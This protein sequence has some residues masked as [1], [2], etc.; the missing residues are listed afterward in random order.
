MDKC[1][2]CGAALESQVQWLDGPSILYHCGTQMS[3]N[4]TY[5]EKPCLERQLTILHA[6]LR[7]AL[8]EW[9]CCTGGNDPY[10]INRYKNFSNRPEVKKIMEEE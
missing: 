6:L 7:D 9:G 2:F 1:P 10:T 5:I 4:R 8:L 3:P